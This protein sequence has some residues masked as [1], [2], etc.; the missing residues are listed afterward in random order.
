MLPI[1]I[2]ALEPILKSFEKRME[3]LEI[4]KRIEAIQTK[5]LL[6]SARYWE[7]SWGPTKT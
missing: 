4:R 5:A 3:E 2:G 6:R 7:E 1:V